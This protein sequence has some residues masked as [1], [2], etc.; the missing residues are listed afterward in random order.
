MSRNAAKRL[1]GLSL[2]SVYLLG[3]CST[4]GGIGDAVGSINPFDKSEEQKKAAQGEVAGKDDRI[5]LLSLDETLQVAEDVVPDSVVLPEAY[6]NT[7]W[8]QVGGNQTHV[9]Q[10][11]EARGSLAKLWSK[12]VGKGSSRKGRVLSPPVVAGGRIFV[13]DADNTVRAIDAGTASE[14][15]E[16]KLSVKLKGKTREGKSGIFERI[17][18]PLAAGDSGGK[19]KESV[20]GGVAFADGK[21]YVTSGLGLIKALDAQTGAEVWRKRLPTPMHSAP[22][23]S[24]GRLFAVSDD[25]ELFAVDANTGDVLWTYQGIVESARMLTA[26]SPAVIDDVVIAPFASGELVALRVQNGGVLWQDALSSSGRLT[27]LS[28]LNDIASGPV[29]ADGYVIA[30]AQ[31]GVMSA[32]DLRTGQRIWSQPAGTLGFPWIAGD[33]VYSVTT[34]GQVVCMSKLTGAVVWLQQLQSFKNEEKRKTRI[35]WAGPIMA[36]GRLLTVSSR[37]EGVEINPYN[38]AITRTFKVGD[39]V[40]VPP[41]IANETVYIINDKA[42]LIA[43]R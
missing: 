31:S 43:L 10:R 4:L 36:G 30:S 34:E 33:F 19:D 22:K 2:V 41:V 38:G 20:G 32:F 39:P 27:P 15:W 25:N 17:T 29:I 3:G 12:D 6:I 37:G 18:N 42:K 40:F 7:D 5:S 24:G 28:S 9:M 35:A 8:P 14:I 13:M 16:H 11:T 23:V 21:I 26:P 1:L